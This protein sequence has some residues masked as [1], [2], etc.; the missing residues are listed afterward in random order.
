MTT[1]KQDDGSDRTFLD[2]LFDKAEEAVSAVERIADGG[3]GVLPM[4]FEDGSRII[5]D[6]IAGEVNS[7][8]G[9]PDWL[10]LRFFTPNGESQ[11]RRYVREKT[12]S[13][14]KV[15]DIGGGDKP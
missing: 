7:T 2:D 8:D 1:E 9:E 3:R 11:T 6:S 4:E 13:R 15:I 12:K 10:V 5:A 14:G